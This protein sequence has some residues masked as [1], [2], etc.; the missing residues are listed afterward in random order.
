MAHERYERLIRNF[1]R[2]VAAERVKHGLSQE[3]LSE[4]ADLHRNAVSKI[5]RGCDDI[6]FDSLTNLCLALGFN[7]AV[8][9]FNSQCINYSASGPGMRPLYDEGV[10][11]KM[12]ILFETLRKE[13]DLSREKLADLIGIHRNTVQR[14]EKGTT[15]ICA[16]TLLSIYRYFGVS[17]V[18]TIHKEKLPASERAMYGITIHREDDD[19]GLPV[20]IPM[21][22]LP[23]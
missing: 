17:E 10:Y 12:G 15:E 18:R 2:I 6:L 4:M 13:Q 8:I 3:C 16:S 11:R 23:L 19:D 21:P 9:D 5:E 14:I 1:G 22:G 7:R 20:Y